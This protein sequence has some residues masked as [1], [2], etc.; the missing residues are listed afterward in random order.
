MQAKLSISTLVVSSLLAA[1]SYA[2]LPGTPSLGWGES[3]FSII[4]VDQSATA[5]NKLIKVKDAADVSVNWNLWN[6]D[7]GDL[8]KVFLDD[9]EVWQGP[10]AASGEATFKVSKGGRYQMQVGLC[11]ADGCSM[12]TS[13]EIVVADTDGSHLKPLNAPM[14]ENNRPYQNK[15]GKVVGTYY[16]EWGVYDR[17]FPVEKMPA[18]NL[19]HVLYGFT[20]ICGG[21]GINDSLKTIEGSFQA[22]QRA[23]E[24]REDF[25]VAIHDPWAAIQMSQSGLSGWNE[26]YKGNFGA[27]MALKQA[28]PELVIL[29]SI[30][31]WTLSDPFFFFDDKAKRAT[32]IESA[33]EFLLTWKFFDGL[34]IDWEFPGGGGANPNLGSS[35]D[36]ETYVTL[37]RE[38][39]AM[40][41][42]LS[43]ETGRTYQLTSAIN[44]GY[45]KLSA[46]NYAD[47][48][49]YM[50]YIFMMGYDFNGAWQ[51]TDLGHQTALYDGHWQ[52]NTKY[53]ADKGTRIL[54]EQG[55][56]PA[57]L[58]LGVAKYGRGWTGVS[59]YS[60]GNP[61]TG[62]ATGPIKGTW[63]DGVIDY[64]DIVNNHMSPEWEYGYDTAAEAPYLFKASSGDLITYDDE[65]SVK[66]KGQYVL[67]NQLAGIFSWE[68]DADN[69]D[70]LNAMHEG[71]GHGEGTTPPVN[72]APIANA[73]ADI[74]VTGPADAELNGGNSRDPEN[75]A[76][77]YL[78]T[79]V[80]GPALTI[81]N[82]DSAIANIE[83]ELVELD[84]EYEFS[85]TV[86]D[87]EGL[88]ATDT[89]TVT[90][91]APAANQAPSVSLV[92]SVAVE[93]AKK[94]SL[95]AKA[96]DADGDALTYAW[97][98]PADI[99]F[100][101]QGSHSITMTAPRVT[102]ATEF[103][104]S[105]T[106]S[107]GS[108]DAS[109]SSLVKVNVKDDGGDNGC[110]A[111]DPDAAN[112]PAWQSA[113]VYTGGDVVSHDNL[114]WQAKY[115]TQG[116][117]PSRTADQWLLVSNVQL[118]WNKGVAY[119]GNDITMHN[120]RQWQA[121][122]WTKGDEPGVASV[123]VDKGAAGCK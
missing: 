5:Y 67:D 114:V 38:L 66:A 12:S 15:T 107:D 34:D 105:V 69:G 71:L 3:Q 22:L 111:T 11:N 46:V 33:R 45:D 95:N 41:D 118:G 109:A 83:L 40:L 39:R 17:K 53:T 44:V 70:L 64:R 25:K 79:Q 74:T 32:F 90:N 55:V 89:V 104:V 43:A 81:S 92:T 119:N 10:A 122:W 112:H 97:T 76:L 49:Q 85:L 80:S 121:K 28:Q 116:N 37:M 52:E 21:D 100:T 9:N 106:V 82:N 91:K 7:F 96:A 36:G 59:D 73:G 31:G 14:L 58:V 88:S 19:T 1:N 16:V 23:C 117:T 18:Q 110:G 63:E 6:G 68:I 51:N 87:I 75:S 77:T 47:A 2:A 108:L 60:N 86:T 123:W 57:K 62:T 101:G 94:V 65:R 102:E 78:W 54:L 4:E 98:V 99:A 24:G 93:S 30:G 13:K 26:P 20:P 56:E 27:L 103:S 48:Q 120:G 115:W 84:T 113:S 72:K 8:A 29:P 50:D 42:E 35:K 61:F